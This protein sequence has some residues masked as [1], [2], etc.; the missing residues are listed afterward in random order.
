MNGWGWEEEKEWLSQFEEKTKEAQAVLIYQCHPI[1]MG[2]IL[3]YCVNIKD[4][5]MLDKIKDI[6]YKTENQ[7][8]G[9]LEPY[10]KKIQDKMR[11]RVDE[12]EIIKT[13]SFYLAKSTINELDKF[14]D[15]TNQRVIFDNI[16]QYERVFSSKLRRDKLPVF[17]ITTPAA[18]LHRQVLSEEEILYLRNRYEEKAKVMHLEQ[19]LGLIQ[20]QFPK[21][22]TVHS[23]GSFLQLQLSDPMEKGRPKSSLN[24]YCLE[25]T[26][27]I[28][29]GD[30]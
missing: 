13:N 19:Q 21:K 23:G 8:I 6:I 26:Y 14:F 24:H 17:T 11:K 2:H 28:R 9:N 12:I 25:L 22:S 18:S 3:E 4:I 7:K 27:D 30:Q 15:G 5:K 10:I 20:T 16:K 29:R 1:L